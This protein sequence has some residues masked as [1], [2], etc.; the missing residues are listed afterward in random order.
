VKP[1]PADDHIPTFRCHVIIS[2]EIVLE[3]SAKDDI[4]LERERVT[5]T[6]ENCIMKSSIDYALLLG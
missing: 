5:K 2:T 1:R 6:E 3:Q 4:C